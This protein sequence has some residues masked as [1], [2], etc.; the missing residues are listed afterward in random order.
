[1]P[2]AVTR[3][4]V[5]PR[6]NI[7]HELRES[8]SNPPHKEKGRLSIINIQEIKHAPCAIHHSRR[9][10]R[11]TGAGNVLRKGFYHKII[12]YIDAHNVSDSIFFRRS[13]DFPWVL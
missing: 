5:A 11:P 4:F 8:I 2:I 7:A 6:M 13:G 3:E 9:P 12:F 1:M 10:S